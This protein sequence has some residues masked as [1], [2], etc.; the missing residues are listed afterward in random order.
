[1][2][3][4]VVA[5]EGGL[6]ETGILRAPGKLPVH[7]ILVQESRFFNSTTRIESVGIKKSKIPL[8]TAQTVDFLRCF[9]I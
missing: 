8:K 9:R 2:D 4:R 5:A 3:A 6:E 1:M 7:S